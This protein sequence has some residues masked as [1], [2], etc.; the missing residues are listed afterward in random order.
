MNSQSNGAK[1]IFMIPYLEV[2]LTAWY[3]RGVS[4]GNV[5]P[6]LNVF[7]FMCVLRF[8]F[9]RVASKNFF[10]FYVEYFSHNVVVDNIAGQPLIIW[11]IFA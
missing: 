9:L 10:M 8:F 5:L 3:F 6:I 7:L 1:F 4:Y 2:W 11:V